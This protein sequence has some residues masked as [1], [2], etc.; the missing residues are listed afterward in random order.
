MTNWIQS[1]IRPFFG[2]VAIQPIVMLWLWA[3]TE[4]MWEHYINTGWGLQTVIT[5]YL[6]PI[7]HYYE[8]IYN[9]IIKTT[10]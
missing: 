6:I 9:R 1:I 8:I 4:N 2:L 10:E 5:L 3:T 7:Y